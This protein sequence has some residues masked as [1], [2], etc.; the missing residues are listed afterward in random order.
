MNNMIYKITIKTKNRETTNDFDIDVEQDD[1]LIIGQH[2]HDG[3]RRLED[4]NIPF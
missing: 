3:I 2:I 1:P 4:D